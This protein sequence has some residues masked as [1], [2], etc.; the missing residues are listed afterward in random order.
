MSRLA[1]ME[2]SEREG[3]H[4]R[5]V[6]LEPLDMAQPR[7]FCQEAGF[8]PMKDRIPQRHLQIQHLQINFTTRPQ[9]PYYLVPNPACPYTVTVAM[10]ATSM[11]LRLPVEI[12]REIYRFSLFNSQSPSAK[13]IYLSG[14][15][16]NSRDPPSPLLQ[17]N[18]Q[19]RDE[20]I[21]LIQTY[22]I[23]LRV[24]HHGRHFDGL[25]ETCFIAQRR[26]RD[27]STI[28]HL[29]IEIWP[30]H[31]DRPVDMIHIWR[32]LRQLR[33]ELR[34]MP[35]LKQVSFFFRDNEI[36]TWTLDGKPLDVLRSRSMVFLG[37]GVDDITTIMDLF[38]RV[39]VAEATFHMPHGLTPGETTESVRDFIQAS[40][41][42]MMGRIPIDED[43]YNDEDAEDA[44]YQDW[45]DESCEADLEIAGAE[46]AQDK[47]DA[48][49]GLLSYDEW[50]E[51]IKIW[52]PKFGYIYRRGFEDED[53]WRLHYVRDYSCESDY[54]Y[55]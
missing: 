42:M 53:D 4:Q 26:P 46:I 43:V 54:Y 28:S 51:F 6:Y 12:R 48:M 19:I 15:A 45:V 32:H 49:R 8:W 30:P 18:G 38:T 14:L 20:V 55:S 22:P 33:T 39:R 35:L 9:H 13:Y 17:V 21:E 25:A 36:S 44:S 41:A 27:Y 1:A 23:T 50:D 5:L 34:H 52:S 10:A 11:F 7:L 37:M 2:S 47:L 40:N 3:V 29:V 24:T 31:P 16:I